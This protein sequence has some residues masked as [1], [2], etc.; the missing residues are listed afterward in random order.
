MPGAGLHYPYTRDDNW[1][2]EA[3]KIRD[4]FIP[5]RTDILIEQ[6]K[7]GG[8]WS[9]LK[10][11]EIS[12]N[13]VALEEKVI[14]VDGPSTLLVKNPNSSSTIY[15][16]TDGSDPRFIGGGIS[17][18]AISGGS[19]QVEVNLTGSGIL[20]TRIHFGD[21]WSPLKEI[22]LISNNE[23]YSKL[24][25]TELHYHPDDLVIDGDTT[26]GK[27]MEF[28]EFKNI[29]TSAIAL[30]GLVLD[31]AVYY[32]FPAEGLLAPGQFYVLASKP[33]KFYLRY[34]MQASGNFQKN[35]SNSGEEI[36]LEDR[37]GKQ[38]IHFSYYDNIPWPLEPD[39]GGYSLVS[40]VYNPTGDP[41]YAV[42]WA[43]S[44]RIGGSPFADEPFPA[45]NG[46]DKLEPELILIYPN[47]TSD[48][49]NVELP[50]QEAG[51]MARI[52]L[53]GI[54]GNLVH[55]EVIYGN[56]TIHLSGLNLSS[57]VY[58]IRIQTEDQVQTGKIVFRQR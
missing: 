31:S 44:Y 53:Y 47:P 15:Y 30:G 39:G 7:T 9:E 57:G 28:I 29:G 49:L 21:D 8:L 4:D 37:E 22:K 58:L 3:N 11:P 40:A 38:V 45:S 10:L 56:S 18:G 27:D 33:S 24:V 43:K 12:K 6:L 54:N 14:Y 35:F 51:Q 2:P 34:G 46:P 20:K 48:V 19:S 36:L 5:Y 16:T 50:W 26:E 17:E 23:D 52:S 32:E 1:L 13:G 41:N 25:I 55:Q 42:Y